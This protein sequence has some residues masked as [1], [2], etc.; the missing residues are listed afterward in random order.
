MEETKKY[1]LRV[2]SKSDAESLAKHANNINI[3]NNL[4][5][6]FPHPYSKKDAL[7]Y[8]S[9][10]RDKPRMEDVAIVIDGKAVGGVGFVTGK[11]VERLNAEIGYWLAEP[12]WGQGI[13]CEA[14]KEMVDYVFSRTEIIRLYAVVFEHNTS[15]MRVL[16]KA[17]FSKVGVLKK[18]CIKNEK[19]ID[20]HHYEL[21]KE[22]I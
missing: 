7:S 3:W 2:W 6:G 14:L 21:V 8:I 16:E 20:L 17:G 5:D 15:S 19:I 10:V 13:V 18:A 9:M 12:Y 1:V 4:R 11:D 22:E